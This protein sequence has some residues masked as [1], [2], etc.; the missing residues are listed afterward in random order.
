MHRCSVAE[1]SATPSSVV[2][3][4]REEAR[5]DGLRVNLRVE[6]ASARTDSGRRSCALRGS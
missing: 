3:N 2:P 6:G 1:V 4:K 5:W